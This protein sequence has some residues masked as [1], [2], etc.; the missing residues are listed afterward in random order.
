MVAV[1]G[2]LHIESAADF[3]LIG[4]LVRA[5]IV[6]R[7]PALHSSPL[8]L[9]WDARAS[10]KLTDLILVV[11]RHLNAPFFLA[12]TLHIGMHSAIRQTL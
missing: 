7:L 1:A 6:Q 3:H 2:Q 9:I 10:S 12:Y 8:G 11:V 4:I 5:S